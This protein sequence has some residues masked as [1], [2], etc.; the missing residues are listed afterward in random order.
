MLQDDMPDLLSEEQ[1]RLERLCRRLDQARVP[2]EI[3]SHADTVGTAEQGVAHGFGSLAEMAPTFLLQ[4]DGGWL[5]AIISGESRLVYKK[6]RKHLGL[7]DIRLASPEV[8]EQ[9]LGVPVGI[10][11]MVNPG[12]PT[13]IDQHLTE[14]ALVYGGCGVPR[15]TLRMRPLDLVSATRAQ[16]FDFTE[17]KAGDGVR[18]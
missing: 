10:V 1:A 4:G 2:Y 3:M 5:C 18:G 16:V 12:M 11:S 6:I 13:L 15:H 14:L 17:L 7:K 9:V 8:V